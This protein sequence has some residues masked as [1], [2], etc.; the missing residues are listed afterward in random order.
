MAFNDDRQMYDVDVNCAKCGK[1]ITQLPFMPS[2]KE[3]G[4]P[5]PVFCADCN[6]EYRQKRQGGGGFNQGGGMNRPRKQMFSGNWTC[7][8]CGTSITE[9]PFE[10]RDTSTL[11]CRA[12]LQ[13]Q[14]AA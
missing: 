13:A 8:S 2:N 10:P 14:R 12:C 4:T 7:S 9:L 11:L 5:R 3:D 1:H 6:R